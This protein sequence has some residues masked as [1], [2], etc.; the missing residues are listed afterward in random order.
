MLLP[1]TVALR[2]LGQ[3]EDTE[4]PPK[5]PRALWPQQHPPVASNHEP[6]GLQQ[7]SLGVP[8]PFFVLSGSRLRI[9]LPKINKI[10]S[11]FITLFAVPG[12]RKRWVSQLEERLADKSPGYPSSWLL[13]VATCL[14]F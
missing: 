6:F 4:Q 5:P 11:L 14:R 10:P 2:S 12:R 13:R 9:V 8:A 7:S 3:R 1:Q